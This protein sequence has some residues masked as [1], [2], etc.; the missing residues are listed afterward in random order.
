MAA[1]T[2]NRQK[3]YANWVNYVRPLQLEPDLSNAGYVEQQ[4]ALSGFAARVRFG[5]YGTGGKVQAGTASSALT[6]V[7]TTISLVRG[8]NPTKLQ[9]T[10]KFTPRLGQMVAGWRKSDSPVEKKLPVEVDVPEAMADRGRIKGATALVQ[11]I[12]DLAL[13]AFYFLLRVGEY[14]VKF[15]GRAPGQLSLNAK[16]TDQFRVRDVR[17]FK[18]CKLGTLRQLPPHAPSDD[19]LSADSSTLR[20]GNQKNGWKNVC[21]HQEANGCTYFCATRAL[22]RRLIYIRDHTPDRDTLLSAYW[23][24]GERRDVNDEDIRGAIKSAATALKYPEQRGIGIN[25]VDTHSLRGGGANAL[26]LAGYS[27]RQIMKMGR[28]KSKTFLEYIREELG[29]FSTG[30]SRQMKKLF[31]YVNV[32]GDRWSDVTDAVV[33]SDYEDV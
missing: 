13:I 27:D 14:T 19:L 31:K 29:S 17:L 10:E 16:Q 3:H 4:R 22:A 24:A 20:L 9:G 30:M 26:H 21:I 28:W 23:V 15:R 7:G 1:T 32:S 25:Q 33:V 5:G 12:G 2:Q 11:A 18:R 6:A 8:A